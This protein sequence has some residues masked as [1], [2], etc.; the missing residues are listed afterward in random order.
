MKWRE[1]IPMKA[2]AFI[3]AV[4]AFTATAI[5]GWYQLANFDALWSESYSADGY[6]MSYLVRSDS[7]YVMQLLEYYRIEE[8]GGTLSA[9]QQRNKAQ[10]EEELSAENTNLRWQLIGSDGSVLRGNT[11]E[12][13]GFRGPEYWY[14]Y[15]WGGG[16][17]V[18]I[19]TAYWP[20]M[21]Q[22]AVNIDLENEKSVDLDEWAGVLIDLV[23][24]VQDGNEA[25]VSEG[26]ASAPDAPVHSSAAVSAEQ[27]EPDTVFT[28]GD[29]NASVLVVNTAQGRYVY[30]PSIENA[31]TVNEFGYR[32]DID[33]L[34]WEKVAEVENNT[35]NLVLWVNRSSMVD[36]QY[37]KADFKLNQWQA[38]RETNLAVTIVCAVAGVLLTA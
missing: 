8:E 38:S 35:A 20:E 2:L 37:R 18:E 34:S 3:A 11:M 33:T 19:G 10:L 24:A 5:M 17:D 22:D 4:A 25:A 14:T 15:Q 16:F 36:D 13:G 28:D 9:F 6:T 1:S 29:N 30:G 27:V 32:F 26:G 23:N 12:T 21:M 7:S 31:L